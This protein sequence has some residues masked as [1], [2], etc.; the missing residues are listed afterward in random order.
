MTDERH[1]P[2]P[3]NEQ[4]SANA[5]FQWGEIECLATWYPQMGGYV[6]KAVVVLAPTNEEPCF[7][8]FVWH[9]GEFPFSEL[10]D[11]GIKPV[12]LHHC[13][14]RSFVEFGETLMEFAGIEQEEKES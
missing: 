8:V 14:G 11:P 10:N 9:N 4:C 5:R 1:P 12:R 7:E 6:G 3:T 13:D 2:E